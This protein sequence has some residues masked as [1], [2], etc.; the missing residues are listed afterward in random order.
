MAVSPSASSSFCSSSTRCSSPRV[1]P[2]RSKGGRSGAARSTFLD[3]LLCT[4]AVKCDFILVP[5]DYAASFA[6][7]HGTQL[8]FFDVLSKLNR[9]HTKDKRVCFITDYTINLA[10]SSTGT[11]SRCSKVEDVEELICEVHS[12]AVGIRMRARPFAVKPH[13]YAHWNCFYEMPVDLL[14]FAESAEQFENLVQVLRFV[15]QQ[16]TQKEMPCRGLQHRE[17]WEATLVLW[18]DGSRVKKNAMIYHR[19]PPSRNNNGNTL[20]KASPSATTAVAAPVVTSPERRL[21]EAPRTRGAR[22]ASVPGR[23]AVEESLPITSPPP[24]PPPQRSFSRPTGGGCNKLLE[25]G[26]FTTPP[27]QRAAAGAVMPQ[28]QGAVV[29][30]SYSSTKRKRNP[31]APDTRN[32]TAPAPPLFIVDDAARLDVDGVV[33]P[34][35]SP[36]TPHIST[37]SHPTQSKM[38]ALEAMVRKQQR[39]I[40]ELR[41]SR[42]SKECELVD[43]KRHLNA[44]PPP[45][46]TATSSERPARKSQLQ[47]PNDSLRAGEKAGKH[48]GDTRHRSCND[49]RHLATPRTMVS[50]HSASSHHEDQLSAVKPI[51]NNAHGGQA[52]PARTERRDGGGGSGDAG[53][54]AVKVA[55]EQLKE[56][57]HRHRQFEE[58]VWSY[59]KALPSE[60]QEELSIYRRR[61]QA[62]SEV[63][64][65]SSRHR[66]NHSSRSSS[67]DGGQQHQRHHHFHRSTEKELKYLR[68]LARKSERAR[69][70][71]PQKRTGAS[72][73]SA[74]EM[75]VVGDQIDAFAQELA[76]K[77]SEI[78][79]L[80][81][82]LRDKTDTRR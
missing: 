28:T 17:E 37:N 69:A 39:C 40:H 81:R 47:L 75:A 53:S 56:A 82:K 73:P 25:S 23:T 14:L 50:Q 6:Y 10:A 80:R 45:H 32:G 60:L 26:G 66:R 68:A 49:K 77:Q 72:V 61:R 41:Q 71:S 19:V 9:K 74:E 42:Y 65:G 24:R 76:R 36:P 18:P 2:R 57:L 31:L 12:R 59:Y 64:M 70:Q 20:L 21:I 11:V 67:S 62:D 7:L 15:Y 8:F 30:Q 78:N 38:K 29:V 58:T 5:P 13:N 52:H 16:C 4:P 48:E 79:S 54:A 43:L 44:V 63:R 34:L 55:E 33:S 27:R 22:S 51:T 46:D 1:N 35:Y 3:E